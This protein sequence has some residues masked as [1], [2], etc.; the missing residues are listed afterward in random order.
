MRTE[1]AVVTVVVRVGDDVRPLVVWA[2]DST[3]TSDR[4]VT[5]F[6]RYERRPHYL[7]AER[8]RFKAEVYVPVGRIVTTAR[9]RWPGPGEIF[10]ATTAG[11]KPLSYDDAMD[12]LDPDPTRVADRA[13]QRDLDARADAAC[14]PKALTRFV[15]GHGLVEGIQPIGHSHAFAERCT[16]RQAFWRRATLAEV[17]A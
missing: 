10:L 12:A 2:G 11:L 9:S 15:G 8:T 5:G 6:E 1:A 14:L 16:A 3:Q 17:R 13:A 4:L 7:D